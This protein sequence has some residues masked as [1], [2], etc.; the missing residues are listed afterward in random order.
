MSWLRNR[1]DYITGQSH[2][3]L[4]VVDECHSN[5]KHHEEM[6]EEWHVKD[7]TVNVECK[8]L[9][10]ELWLSECEESFKDAAKAHRTPQELG[11]DLLRTT[12]AKA[13]RRNWQIRVAS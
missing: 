2:A 12:K 10:N 9:L 11:E 8:K 5:E 13:L 4:A 1:I 3:Q 6:Q 7:D